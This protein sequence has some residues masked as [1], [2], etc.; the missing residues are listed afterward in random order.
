MSMKFID[1]PAFLAEL[2]EAELSDI[3]PDLDLRIGSPDRRET[4]RLLADCACV[5]I[6]HTELDAE[7]LSS[8]DSL[9]SIV[10]LGTGASSYID[11][12]A[13]EAN[14]IR[15]RTIKGY[16]DRSVAEH[17]AALMFA[18]ARQVALMDRGIRGDDWVT[19]DGV[20]LAG[21]TLGVI[22]TG[23]IGGEMVKIGAGLGMN[24]IAWNRSGVPADLPAR[25]VELDDL[26]AAADVVSIHLA[27]TDETT[28]LID[29]R[30]LGL[31]AP[32]SFLINTARG[33]VIDEPALVEALAEQRIAHAGLDVFAEEP[34]GADH[35]LAALDNVT[36][37]AHAG[38]MTREASLNLLRMG[39]ELMVEERALL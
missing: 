30:R 11:L 32:H 3:V 9:K 28:G 8:T 26:M 33:G 12:A 19:R 17:A 25:Q 1:C 6:D 35:P 18:A 37:T 16:G 10:F 2:Y 21:K 29:R 22:G 34:I 31:M 27:L 7:I 20:E 4:V 24:V 36:L 39:L 38:F 13:A 15:V 14:D 5:I 23:G